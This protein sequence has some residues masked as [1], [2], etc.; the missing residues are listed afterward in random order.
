MSHVENSNISDKEKYN[1]LSYDFLKRLILLFLFIFN[2]NIISG[3]HNFK[4]YFI[5]SDLANFWNN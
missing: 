1:E 5:L 3:F 2:K 4:H